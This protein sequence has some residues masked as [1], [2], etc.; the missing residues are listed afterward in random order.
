MLSH[1]PA[2]QWKGHFGPLFQRYGYGVPD[3]ERA[4]RSASNALTLIVQDEIT[5]Y[6]RPIRRV[7]I[8]FTMK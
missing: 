4:R 3:M 2:K 5:P 7:A 6:P 1:L 8:T